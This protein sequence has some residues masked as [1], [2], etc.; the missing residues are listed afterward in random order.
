MIV[1][2]TATKVSRTIGGACS[3][4]KWRDLVGVLMPLKSIIESAITESNCLITYSTQEIARLLIVGSNLNSMYSLDH[5][6]V[7]RM[8]VL[9]PSKRTPIYWGK[10]TPL[11]HSLWGVMYSF[12]HILAFQDTFISNRAS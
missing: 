12:Y 11:I 5:Q 7:I 8:W 1:R 10:G 4:V 3:S 9:G 6:D 2:R